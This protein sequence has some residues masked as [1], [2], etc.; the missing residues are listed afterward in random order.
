MSGQIKRLGKHAV[1]Y[2]VGVIIGKVASFIML[3]IYTRYLTPADYGT[4]ELLEMTTDVVGMIAGIGLA[5]SVFRF[6]SAHE[7]PRHKA[8]VMSTATTAVLAL[9]VLTGVAGYAFAAPI[10]HLVFKG[11]KP[12]VYFH[13]FFLIYIAQSANLIPFALLR[14]EEKSGFFVLLNALQLVTTLTLN[15]VF[16]VGRHMGVTGVL[17]STLI[18]SGMTSIYLTVYT[19][20]RIGM[21]FSM[22]RLRELAG[23]GAPLVLWSLGSFVL[24]FSDRY[25]LNFYKGTAVVG[26]YS[27]GYKFGFILMAFAV[28]PFSLVWE[29]RRFEIAKQPDA[30]DVFNR[31]FVYLN[32]VL[33]IGAFA[34]TVYVKDFLRVMSDRAFLSAYEVVP[35]IMLAYIL[36]AWTTYCN[37]GLYLENRTD[38][39]AWTAV[40]SVVANIALNF[41]WIPTYGMFGAAWATLGAFAVRFA[42][43]YGWSQRVHA[44]HYHW[45]RVVWLLALVAVG[46]A[47]HRIIPDT[48]LMFTLGAN[49][50]IL[51]VVVTVAYFTVLTGSERRTAIRIVGDRVSPLLSWS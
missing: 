1:V 16:V 42:F 39:I 38:L 8:S 22:A 4:L 24:T 2:A 47:L 23:F 3:P 18:S 35:I 10:T 30:D 48:H 17:L 27:L 43:I 41:L 40:L 50:L 9:A 51:A 34:I 44:I 5:S 49:T 33:L 19:Y 21:H 26:I 28:R 7:D 12:T 6:Y 46:Y 14:A 36:Q 32:V 37:T 11:D 15:I 20:R 13:L 45:G 25:F 29:P 31:M